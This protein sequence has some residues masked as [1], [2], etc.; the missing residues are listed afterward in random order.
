MSNAVNDN[1]AQA[2]ANKKKPSPL[3]TAITKLKTTPQ[4]RKIADLGAIRALNAIEFGLKH[5]LIYLGSGTAGDSSARYAFTGETNAAIEAH[6]D[7]CF[8]YYK[9]SF[10]NKD[11]GTVIDLVRCHLATVIDDNDYQPDPNNKDAGRAIEF[12]AQAEGL[13]L[14]WTSKKV[15]AVKLA[16]AYGDAD[17]AHD[18]SRTQAYAIHGFTHGEQE[19]PKAAVAA[20][21]WAQVLIW[22]EASGIAP[23]A[24]TLG[25]TPAAGACV[26]PYSP[27]YQQGGAFAA[28]V[29]PWVST[30]TPGEYHNGGWVKED[31]L[32]AAKTDPN[33][34][35]LHC[36]DLDGVKR[37][38]GSDHLPFISA[39]LQLIRQ[40]ARAGF[41]PFSHEWSSFDPKDEDRAKSHIWFK[42]EEP[43]PDDDTWVAHQ[44]LLHDAVGRAALRI[45]QPAEE[46]AALL[47]DKACLQT[48][49]M[50]RVAGHSK[51]RDAAGV[52][53]KGPAQAIIT[54][55]VWPGREVDFTA[56]IETNPAVLR[57]EIHGKTGKKGDAIVSFGREVWV[58]KGLLEDDG[59]GGAT[60]KTTRYKLAEHV[61]PLESTFDIVEQTAGF[62]IRYHDAKG[63]VKYTTISNGAFSSNRFYAPAAHDLAVEGVQLETNAGQDLI[64]NLGRWEREHRPSSADLVSRNGWFKDEA[65]SNLVYVNGNNVFGANWR[66]HGPAIDARASRKGTLEG[67][68]NGVERLTKTPAQVFALGLSFAGALVGGLNLSGAAIVDSF[69]AHFC[70]DS[71]NG[72]TTIAKVAASV[73]NSPAL[74]AGVHTWVTTNNATE[75]IAEGSS[76]ALLVLDELKEVRDFELSRTIHMLND[77]KGKDRMNKDGKSNQRNKAWALCYLS[78]GERSTKEVLGMSAQGGHSVR[79]PDIRLNEGAACIDIHHA[80]AV[81]AFLKDHYG[82]VGD[83]WA[84]ELAE[85]PIDEWA[86]VQALAQK[87]GKHLY[88]FTEGKEAGRV[89]EKFGYVLAA[90]ELAV[91]V[92][93]LKL[94][95]GF[96]PTSVCEWAIQ[97]VLAER[98]KDVSPPARVLSHIADAV[99]TQP[100]NYPTTV[101]LN[102]GF[103]P[104]E[105]HGIVEQPEGYDETPTGKVFLTEAMLKK[106]G[107]LDG[108]ACGPRQFTDWLESTGQGG[109]VKRK[110]NGKPARSRICAIQSTWYFIDLNAGHDE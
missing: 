105:L 44:Q 88:T 10:G 37:D 101:Y 91:V 72:K 85:L 16:A 8:S 102:K 27:G 108:A 43:A 97:E 67:W 19:H 76:G 47:P 92:G 103:K 54:E 63:R 78:T 53:K 35:R 15:R 36:V 26:N 71:S 75:I 100:A 48:S 68:V 30:K 9:V 99:E 11:S 21:P 31:I 23:E 32:K 98:G 14:N 107:V 41:K 22:A 77:G 64:E 58:T 60:T 79:M 94:P 34:R 81:E 62:R 83:A 56:L 25:F 50:I 59:D 51:F 24:L 20:G 104:I 29:G 4:T 89:A 39:T 106:S 2:P 55:T 82:V 96:T 12:I 109:P 42:A 49:R 66:P 33:A 13:N 38:D 87:S 65:T 46:Q 61:Y 73:W 86:Q 7:G 95:A 84:K 52:A 3:A 70:G 93:F 69:G 90:L 5:D 28:K 40:L 18:L 45:K 80:R 74:G 110:N 6:S 17:N 57:Y 1:P